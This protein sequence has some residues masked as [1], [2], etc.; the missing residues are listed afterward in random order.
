[1]TKRIEG[2]MSK[3]IEIRVSFGGKFG[4]S[5][6]GAAML[7]APILIGITATGA[8]AAPQDR[9]PARK[10]LAFDAASV[11]PASVPSGVAASGTTVMVGKGSGVDIPRNT[12]GPGRIHYS[13][14]SL[15][16]LLSQAYDSDSEIAGPGWL[17][18]QFV[19]VDAT[20]PP[21]T[22]K[23][24][25]REMLRNFITDR[26]KLQYHQESREVRGYALVVAK[27]GLKIK[28]SPSAPAPQEPEAGGPPKRPPIG[29]DGFPARSPLA[30]GK[31]GTMVF[32]G[33]GGRRRLYAQQ[34]TMHDFAGLLELRQDA[35]P[36]ATRVNVTDATGLTGKY[37][38]TLT[39]SR[40]GAP[41]A[42]AVADIFGAVQSELGLRL[43]QKKT[44]VSVIVIDRME[45]APSE[46]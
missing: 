16:E 23:E 20:F 36:N 30:P 11:K 46:N 5:L 38:F 17:D 22:T 21:N 8:A 10:Q 9:P 26:F 42:E 31:P 41:D 29:S 37:D 24:Q 40:E 35:G 12:G 13:L 45:K 4:L 3:R 25:L 7:A 15:K 1:M 28:E 33:Q 6:A 2:I 27:S 18:S 39:Y 43:E 32:M 44:E 14:I 34:Q 19:Q